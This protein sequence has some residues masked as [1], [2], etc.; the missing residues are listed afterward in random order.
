[1][2]K[3]LSPNDSAKTWVRYGLD[4]DGLE[5]RYISEIIGKCALV[6]TNL[7]IIMKMGSTKTILHKLSKD[8]GRWDS[9]K[10]HRPT[11]SHL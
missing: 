6:F 3:R 9:G 10:P 8:S 1:M 5:K 2:P 11:N 4:Q 7:M